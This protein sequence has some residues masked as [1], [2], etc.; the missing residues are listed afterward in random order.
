MRTCLTLMRRLW[1]WLLL[2]GLSGAV[3]PDCSNLHTDCAPADIECNGWATIL[4]AHT[5]RNTV[6]IANYTGNIHYSYN[7]VS[8]SFPNQ[9]TGN[10]I[11]RFAYGNGL[12]V[13]VGNN[14]AIV[15]SANLENWT[16]AASPTANALN[17]ITY[18]N[19]RF[20]AVG[21]SNTVLVSGDGINW[22]LETIGAGI[23][24]QDVGYADGLFVTSRILSTDIYYS[25]TGLSGTWQQKTIPSSNHLAFG[26]G[27]WVFSDGVGNII[28]YSSDLNNVLY[29]NAAASAG[30][31]DLIF[32]DGAF[33]SMSAAGGT[34]SRSLNGDDATWQVFATGCPSAGTA[35]AISAL[36]CI[37]QR[38]V[39]VGNDNSANRAMCTSSN[40]TAGSFTNITPVAGNPTYGIV[41]ALDLG[42]GL[43]F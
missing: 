20:V 17:G 8:W 40:G 30:S 1:M 41:Q 4:L 36:A 23:S 6:F 42:P 13:G 29:A 25:T 26:N 5:V 33:Y 35:Q 24:L 16:L 28:V 34:V 21:A 27:R 31:N 11:N 32:T 22:T 39:I 14:G 37:D 2:C 10:V 7:G 19:E 43:Q 3:L 9:V 15:Y 18:G 38:C 12:I